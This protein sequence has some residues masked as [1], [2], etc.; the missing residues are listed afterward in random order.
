MSRFTERPERPQGRSGFLCPGVPRQIAKKFWRGGTKK[1]P[2]LGVGPPV[3]EGAYQISWYENL[4][5]RKERN[6]RFSPETL[7]FLRKCV[8]HYDCNHL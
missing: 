3:W 4:F 7:D 6:G 1:P 5:R 8:Y 2:V